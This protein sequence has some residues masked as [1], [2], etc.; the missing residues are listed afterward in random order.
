MKLEPE[1]K[2]RKEGR[3]NKNGE[4]EDARESEIIKS[5]RGPVERKK[6]RNMKLTKSR[7]PLYCIF[8]AG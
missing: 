4:K 6:E 8:R 5:P 7:S 3:R 1:R 2:G